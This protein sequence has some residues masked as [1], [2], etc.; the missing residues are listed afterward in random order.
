[1]CLPVHHDRCVID[2]GFGPMPNNAG[3]EVDSYD[4]LIV[5]C[6]TR[7]SDGYLVDV[8]MW[9]S[10]GVFRRGLA[11]LT[12]VLISA[13]IDTV[14]IRWKRE[15]R[16]WWWPCAPKYGWAYCTN[17]TN[18]DGHCHQGGTVGQV[19]DQVSQPSGP[20]P[21]P[22]TLISL[23]PTGPLPGSSDYF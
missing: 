9:G 23:S 22:L 13:T 11:K 15:R 4:A 14:M 5:E 1:M 2:C 7:G 17:S 16:Y 3:G 8:G 18:P 6:E 12:S 10:L 21:L 19:F 20:P